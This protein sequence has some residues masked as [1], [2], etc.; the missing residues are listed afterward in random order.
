MKKIISKTHNIEMTDALESAV[1]SEFS[2]V[3][4]NFESLVVED[5]IVTLETNQ[6][7]K[8]DKHQVTVR[9]P[10][11]GNDVVLTSKGDDMYKVISESAHLA[12]RQMRKLKTKYSKK[13][14]ESIRSPQFS[15]DDEE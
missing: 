4:D 10:V 11:T 14:S 1:S 6:N 3:I 7:Q 12:T 13:G 9:I 8:T 5:I 2:T 15:P